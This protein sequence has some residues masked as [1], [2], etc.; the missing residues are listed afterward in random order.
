MG[1]ALAGAAIDTGFDIITS[2]YCN[3][4]MAPE[5]TAPEKPTC[6]LIEMPPGAVTTLQRR[7]D[8]HNLVLGDNPCEA[9]RLGLR[10]HRRSPA[11]LGVDA[12][13]AD[14]DR[15]A[16]DY[17]CVVYG[18]VDFVFRPDRVDLSRDDSSLLRH[19]LATALDLSNL[20][21]PPGPDD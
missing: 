9:M 19:R 12:R 6:R 1:L 5:G 16:W 10:P 14:A 3:V 4:V 21:P 18:K 13:R 2:T 8:L 11:G 7:L 17:E 15:D 20:Y